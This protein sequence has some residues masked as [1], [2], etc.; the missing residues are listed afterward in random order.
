MTHTAEPRSQTFL[1]I[2]GVPVPPDMDGKSLLP[3]LLRRDDPALLAST[4]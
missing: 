2:A 3:H 4:A 1:G